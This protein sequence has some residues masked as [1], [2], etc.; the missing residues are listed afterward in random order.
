MTLTWARPTT[1]ESYTWPR[2]KL[3]EREANVNERLFRLVGKMSTMK[4]RANASAAMASQRLPSAP[5]RSGVN[6]SVAFS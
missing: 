3:D 2:M 1:T 4:S 6:A 5:M